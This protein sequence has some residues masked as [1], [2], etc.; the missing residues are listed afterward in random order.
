VAALTSGGLLLMGAV[1]TAA[2]SSNPASNVAALHA[3]VA[4]LLASSHAT[5]ALAVARRERELADTSFGNDDDRTAR[6]AIDVGLAAEAT[7][8]MSEA[9]QAFRSGIT[10]KSNLVAKRK[11]VQSDLREMAD[12]LN[13]YGSFLNEQSRFRE[14]EGYLDAASGFLTK[15][16]PFDAGLAVPI[17]LSAASAEL[18]L[19]H[20][21]RAKDLAN[22]MLETWKRS[23][24]PPDISV[25]TVYN[26][27][28]QIA[29]GN[30]DYASAEAL[31][32]KAL[33]IRV[34]GDS[35]SSLYGS[36]L[37]S[38]GQAYFDDAT[39]GGHPS[40]LGAAERDFRSALTVFRASRATYLNVYYAE[41]QLAELE[42]VRGRYDQSVDAFEK[43]LREMRAY[44]DANFAYMSEN[45]RL[46]F[47][48]ATSLAF[49]Q[50]YVV[51]SDALIAT[52]RDTFADMYDTALWQKGL[53]LRGIES[54]R[55]QLVALNDPELD[56][57][58]A[59]ITRNRT[60]IAALSVA[61]KHDPSELFDDLDELNSEEQELAA[62][63]HKR[64]RSVEPAIPAWRQIAA[65]LGPSD[66]AIEFV[67]A[68]K[69]YLALVLRHD[70]TDVVL[71]GH[72]EQHV[73]VEALA[74]YRAEFG[75]GLKRD[76]PSFYDI[77]WKPLLPALAGIS[78]IYV[79]T[80]GVLDQ[81]PFDAVA[82]DNGKL[83]M[84]DFDM[85]RVASTGV[86]VEPSAK[87][88]SS[89]AYL[90]GDPQYY[91]D[92]PDPKTCDNELRDARSAPARGAE[93]ADLPCTGTEVREAA[94]A[95][96]AHGTT[97][98]TEIGSDAS[99]LNLTSL[100]GAAIVHIATHG[101]FADSAAS[102]GARFGAAGGAAE[103]EEPLMRSGLILA[104][105]GATWQGLPA[106]SADDN[107]IL[108]AYE[109]AD[110]DLQ[111]TELVVL[112]ACDSGLGEANAGEGVF[113]LQRG[114]AEAGTKMLMMS[115]WS[116]PDLETQEL[117]GAFYEKWLGG[118]GAFDALHAAEL[119]ERD[120]V[121][122]RYGADIPKF[123]AGFMLVMN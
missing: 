122:K 85:Y 22:M 107:G 74:A 47:Q 33:A 63:L 123:W 41:E 119:Q 83:L 45:D 104:G 95:L 68:G 81:I 44:F 59:E 23:H 7:G 113:G 84:Q 27:L 31:Y 67:D 57:L 49:Q 79:S 103:Y 118:M 116:V 73:S 112:S 99:K 39:Y 110:L 37:M 13:D 77:V 60:H 120:V 78:R 40:R 71:L 96:Q 48:S 6:A 8:Q 94:S 105:G 35:A 29:D 42:G 115:M 90:F 86:L 12:Y 28:G 100:H 3:Q 76:G 26:I 121:E 91:P 102:E 54:L 101:F 4:H 20:E 17:L 24:R 87:P 14:A 15:M 70:R 51:A 1:S 109:A 43:L 66:A 106:Q 80:D 55:S 18:Q 9:E 34:P 89:R 52:H 10:A 92:R 64:G 30:D 36:L 93:I 19:G 62:D 114:F 65:R 69:L 117:L 108:T 111:G 5:E 25:R 32:A 53:V 56:R 58:F 75:F 46:A 61:E 98:V 21:A 38:A 97:V 2:G 16:H 88:A 50:F 82:D 11:I 72:D